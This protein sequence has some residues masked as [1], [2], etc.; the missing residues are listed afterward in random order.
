[1][2]PYVA[3]NMYSKYIILFICGPPR[4]MQPAGAA[5]SYFLIKRI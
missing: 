5:L 1:M 3:Y 2:D 4:I